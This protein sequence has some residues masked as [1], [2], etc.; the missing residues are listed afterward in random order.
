MRDFPKCDIGLFQQ[1]F[2]PPGESTIA[3]ITIMH[4][5]SKNDTWLFQQGGALT[6]VEIA[7]C[8]EIV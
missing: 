7:K 3:K 5:L 2:D 8:R 4:D 6:I 1:W